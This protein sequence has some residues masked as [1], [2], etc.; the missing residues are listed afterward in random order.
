MHSDSSVRTLFCADAAG[1]TADLAHARNFFAL[2]LGRAGNE[3]G[4]GRRYTLYNSLRA[5]GYA[6][7]AGNTSVG[8]YLSK[9]ARNFN[10]VFGANCLAVAAT[11][12]GVRAS[13]VA[14]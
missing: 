13:L 9:S 11:Q 2:A 10:C 7:S 8:V 3:Y 12:A 6:R 14:A 5:S 1:N 4:S